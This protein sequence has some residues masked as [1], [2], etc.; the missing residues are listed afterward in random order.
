V[1]AALAPYA[2]RD[3]TERMLARRALAASDRHSVVRLISSVPGASVGELEPIQP[4]PAGDRRIDALLPALRGRR[5]RGF[6]LDRLCA[7]LLTALDEW[8]AQRDSSDSTV[9]RLLDDR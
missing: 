9:R 1:A 8:Q 5:W 4:A 7:E 3:L 2:W 6:S